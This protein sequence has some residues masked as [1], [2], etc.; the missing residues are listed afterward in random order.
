MIYSE[1]DVSVLI[2]TYKYAS[3]ILDTVATATASSAGEILVLDDASDDGTMQKLSNLSDP[4]LR[5]LSQPQNVGLWRNH[6]AAVRLA[7]RPW[8]KFLQADDQ[9][10][11]GALGRMM[12]VANERTSL[13]WSNPIFRELSTGKTWI[14]YE[15]PSRITL[16]SVAAFKFF[17]KQSFILGTPSHMLVRRTAID[18][19][20]E[21]WKN[22]I[23]ADVI[24]GA[25][26]AAAGDTILL[27]AGNIVQGIHDRQDGRTQG[28]EKTYMRLLNTLA[29]LEQNKAKT[30]A[31]FCANYSA[32][33]SIGLIRS[34][35]GHFR[36]H[37]NI[38]I[39]SFRQFEP[40]LQLLWKQK[41]KMT[42]GTIT[43]L[44]RFKYAATPIQI[45]W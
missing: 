39:S 15:L 30:P 8:I 31:S 38:G 35:L 24:L 40:L 22:E 21:A 26:A 10:T 42:I 18:M 27:P 3:L 45:V 17:T 28:M 12:A 7:T 37:G 23:S 41:S 5:V 20:D 25:N 11:E 34:M 43:E 9:L 32:V 6:Q 1:S 14:R 13:V 36:R 16:D 4:R 19:S 29:Y 44:V 2:P 33:E